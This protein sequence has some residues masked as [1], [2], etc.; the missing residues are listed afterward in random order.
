MT[1]NEPTPEPDLTPWIP[2][3]AEGMPD[4]PAM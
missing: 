1:D 4:C 2:A 3:T